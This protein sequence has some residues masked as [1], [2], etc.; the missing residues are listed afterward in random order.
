MLFENDYIIAFMD[1]KPITRGHVLLIP[2]KHSELL[3][4][5]DDRIAGQ[6]MI[7]AK[8]VAIALK[9]SKLNC[10]G[11]NYI[12]SDGAEAGQHIFHV[13]MHVIPRYR[14]DGFGLRMPERD[15]E[16]SDEKTLERTAIK[17]RKMMDSS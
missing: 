12:L 2:K 4:E 7:A 13:H 16:E 14:A 8:K 11:I 3:V 10:K 17:I 9:K 1:N 5:L 6:M 15:E